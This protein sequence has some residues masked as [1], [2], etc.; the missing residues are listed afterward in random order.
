M[1]NNKDIR[2]IQISDCHL[3]SDVQKKWFNRHPELYL[4]KVIQDINNN[5]PA[6][7]IVLATGDLS[8]DGSDSSYLKLSRYFS[9]FDKKTYTLAGN[10]DDLNKIKNHLNHEQMKSTS[11]FIHGNWLVLLLDTQVVEQE[12]GNLSKQQL[13]LAEELLK[14]HQNK[15]V[16]IAMHHPP[17][18]INCAWI[19]K[20]NLQN[21]DEFITLV[22]RHKNIKAVTFGHVH[23]AYETIIDN[24]QYLACPSTCHQFSP[25]SEK[26]SVDDINAGYRW[27][28]LLNNG[29]IKTGITR[30]VDDIH[31]T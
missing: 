9:S 17:I 29:R 13:S 23:Q 5:E 11:Y 31:A 27:F 28:D 20:I 21:S 7:S 8:H 25:N 15:Y 3:S 10:H 19:D 22:S 4:K 16:L 30:I 6:D 12:Y 14:T 18:H 24:I 1:T 2:I 26:F